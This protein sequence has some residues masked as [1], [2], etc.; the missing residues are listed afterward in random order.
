ME[1]FGSCLAPSAFTPYIGPSQPNGS[2]SVRSQP[3]GGQGQHSIAAWH[4]DLTVSYS[5]SDKDAFGQLE[6]CVRTATSQGPT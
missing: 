3:A 4:S 6:P 5:D 1:C 2:K